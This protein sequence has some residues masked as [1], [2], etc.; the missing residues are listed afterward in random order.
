MTNHPGPRREVVVNYAI[1][2]VFVAS[3][4]LP[5]LGLVNSAL[6]P[7][8]AG[9]ATLTIPHSLHLGNLTTAWR[10]G[11]FSQYMLSS[12]I[13]SGGAT[14]LCCTF[15]LLAG[16]A[17][18]TMTFRGREVIFYIFLLGIMVPEEAVIVPLYFDLRSLG[19]TDTY[20]S[21]I[22]PQTAGILS[23]GIF[24]MRAFFKTTSPALREAAAMDGA[25]SWT[26]L[27]RILLPISRPALVTLAMLT[28]MWTWNE[29]LL[30]LVMISTESMRTAPLG[31]SFFRSE[32]VT[33]F[34]LLSAAALIV[35]APVVVLY[36]F[37][38]RKFIA[39]MMSGAI[40]E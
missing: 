23:F 22:L 34:S 25:S 29:F 14:I 40:K 13:V 1:L 15:S 20:G 38:N 18:G 3:T 24:W 7:P 33:Q 21:L 31:L 6:G 30:P 35:A 11:H 19:L 27:T 5:L 28:F 9:T 26:I 2:G 8:G 17:L 10:Q 32:Y 39:G 12:L 4:L 37:F 36:L 16:Y